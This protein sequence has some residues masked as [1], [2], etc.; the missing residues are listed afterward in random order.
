MRI[1][2]LLSIVLSGFFHSTAQIVID[3]AKLSINTKHDEFAPAFYEDGLILSSNRKSTIQR[4]IVEVDENG[5]ENFLNQLHYVSFKQDSAHNNISFLK[6]NDPYINNG[7]AIFQNSVLLLAKPQIT[8]VK[9]NRKKYGTV[10]IFFFEKNKDGLWNEGKPFQHNSLSINISHPALSKDGNTLYFVSNDPKG[11]GGMDIWKSE[12]NKN[13]SWKDPENLGPKI[14]TKYNEV[15]PTVNDNSNLY[16]SSNKPSEV[17]GEVGGYDL[18]LYR[19]ESE[20]V[21]QLKEPFNSKKDDFSYISNDAGQTGFFS[22]NRYG[23]DDVFYF[24]REAN[25]ESACKKSNKASKCF[26]FADGKTIPKG[27]IIGYEWDFGDGTREHSQSV[28]HCF[29]A[30]GNY[31]VH[32]SIIDSI[33]G[34]KEKSGPTLNVKVDSSTLF[35]LKQNDPNDQSKIDFLP[36]GKDKS[37]EKVQEVFWKFD[38]KV[39]YDLESLNLP[40]TL[41]GVYAVESHLLLDDNSIYCIAD[42]IEIKNNNT[43]NAELKYH[44]LYVSPEQMFSNEIKKVILNKQG[45]TKFV[46][47]LPKIVYS[48][49]EWKTSVKE[50]F[51]LV[52]NKGLEIKTLDKIKAITFTINE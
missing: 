5:E 38:N 24:K 11:Y 1:I 26:L 43:E 30:P 23:N 41:P 42:T 36:T 6:L 46:L 40:A 10:G 35:Y 44:L 12:K 3:L 20:K 22:S 37:K 49:E 18:Y 32:M 21:N 34:I 28:K 33:T 19:I 29:T 2:C 39:L 45:S 51:Q 31:K 27:S 9:K 14:N 48:D 13:G 16:F 47:N 25:L 7:P 50:Y 52:F 4:T 17:A 15:F 8:K